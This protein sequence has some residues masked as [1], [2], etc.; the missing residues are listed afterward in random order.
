[1]RAVA[2]ITYMRTDS[3]RI[4]DEALKRAGTHQGGVR[5]TSICRKSR[6]TMRHPRTRRAHEAIRP[7]D[8]SQRRKRS[9]KHLPQEQ[10]RLY[11]LIYQRF[12]ACQ[13][14][15]AIFAVTNIEVTATREFQ[16]AGQRQVRRLSQVYVQSSSKKT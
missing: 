3:T 11:T 9:P 10:L 12:I 6:I 1:M 16:S 14:L 4:A 7:T 5:A 15:P 8:L 2:L 13:M